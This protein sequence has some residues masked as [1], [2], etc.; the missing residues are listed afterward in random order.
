VK[1]VW[2]QDP[3]SDYL[4]WQV[5]GRKVLQRINDLIKDVTGGADQGTPHEG[6]GKPEALKH[7]L[8]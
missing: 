5:Q 6:I 1:Y 8:H 3:W 2:D 7:G 4:N